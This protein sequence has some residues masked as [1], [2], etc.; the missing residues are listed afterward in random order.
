MV[1][2]RDSDLQAAIGAVDVLVCDT[3]YTQAEYPQKIGWGHGTFDSAI[4]MAQ[5]LGA[6]CLVCTHHEPMRSDDE[7]ER[8]FAEA[9]ARHPSPGC[10]VMLAHEGLEITL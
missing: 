8:V 3:S 4:A 9:L 2:Q 10:E 7:L 1:E 6:R 5:R